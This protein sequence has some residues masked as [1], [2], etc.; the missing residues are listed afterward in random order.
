[1]GSLFP[2]ALLVRGFSTGLPEIHLL[3]VCFRVVMGT[4]RVIFIGFG[5]GGGEVD[6]DNEKD[7]LTSGLDTKDAHF[8]LQ[9][10]ARRNKQEGGC[11]ILPSLPRLEDG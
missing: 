4:E 9:G 8:S 1:M 11:L 3:Q 2:W 6:S 5:I 7:L 10:K